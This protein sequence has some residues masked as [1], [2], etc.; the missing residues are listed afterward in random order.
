MGFDASGSTQYGNLVGAIFVFNLIVGVGALSLPNA[1][2]Y[3]GMVRT[4]PSCHVVAEN[5]KDVASGFDF[6]GQN[7]DSDNSVLLVPR[8]HLITLPW[9]HCVYVC[10]IPVGIHVY[11]E[12]SARSKGSTK[13][14][15]MFPFFSSSLI[16]NRHVNR[17][18]TFS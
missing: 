5:A 15:S 3:A 7:L 16:S 17:R 8:Y 2:A 6:S 1:F 13:R 14:Q 9:I 12:R 4:C 11:R 18:I 10:H